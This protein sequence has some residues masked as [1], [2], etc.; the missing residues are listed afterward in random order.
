MIDFIV[1]MLIKPFF[2][3]KLRVIKYYDQKYTAERLLNNS[4]PNKK[5]KGLSLLFELAISYPYRVQEVINLIT[6][7]LRK[8]FPQENAIDPQHSEV[9]E[10]GVRSLASI[11][12]LDQ[13]GFPYNFDVHQIRIADLDLTRI[14]EP[15]TK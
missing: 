2:S 1:E 7:F 15:T 5:K 11:P 13:N 4:D 12:R 9:L 6:A 14:T 8:N 10:F 3:E